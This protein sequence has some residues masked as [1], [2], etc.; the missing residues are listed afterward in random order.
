MPER[1]D[2]LV[3]G[4]GSGGLAAARRAAGHGARV[5]LVE[6]GHLGGTCV[7]VGCVP[8]KVMWYA[9]ELAHYLEDA[10]GYGFEEVGGRLDWAGLVARREEY[11]E[12]LRG[13]YA[14]NLDRDGVTL[15]RGR[16]RFTGERSVTVDDRTLEA[17]HVLI[18]TGSRPAVPGVPGAELG[19]DSDGFFALREQPRRVA[20]VGGG[21]IALELAGVLQ[22][23]G[24]EVTIFI[25]REL[26]LKHFDPMLREMVMEAMEAQ[27]MRVRNGTQ[28]QQLERG[29]QEAITVVS[30]Q[31]PESESFDTVIWATG[32][33]ANTQGLNLAATGVEPDEA[34]F[35][36][37]DE[38]QETGHPGITAVGDVTGEWM[39]T[40][41]AIAAGRRLA[42]RLFGNRP[43]S[44]LD[45]RDI[46][47]VVFSHPPI[48]TVG[49]SED[50]ACYRYGEEAV[51]T[52]S[53]R[54]KPMY[55]ALSER[56]LRT[57]MK[58]VTVGAEE[59]VVGVHLIGKDVDEI[60]QG[61]AV[62]V[63]M[64]ATKADLDDTV[65]LHPTSAEELVTLK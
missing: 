2:F 42:D 63:K 5:A 44:R 28:V 50:E 12:R 51:T 43:G 36:A 35:I 18:A 26:P 19:I 7:N 62:A 60:L 45:Y 15:V 48:G 16:A 31:S 56:D 32:R 33:A 40:P 27:G 34:G 8:K 52:Y 38:W 30:D 11:I 9:A 4:A 47:T 25:R 57:G 3:I 1:Y 10:S 14:R 58:V 55:G 39:L 22:A 59:R 21:Y 65:A 53:T 46:P 64:G 54:F 17:E 23:L 13:I 6:D 20:V 37:V 49:M 24:S 41:V 61:F 29:D